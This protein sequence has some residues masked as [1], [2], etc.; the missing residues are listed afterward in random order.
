L[1]EGL[2]NLKKY[3]NCVDYII[4]HCAPYSLER[5]IVGEERNPNILTSYIILGSLDI[6]IVKS[7]WENGKS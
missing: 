1:R 4:I 3:H 7:K 2:S 5:R 6:T